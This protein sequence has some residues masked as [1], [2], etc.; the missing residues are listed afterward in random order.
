MAK[1]PGT[2]YK[3]MATV[4]GV[5]GVCPAGHQLGEHFP[6]GCFDG[7]GLCG[8][9]YHS[10]FGD[11]QTLQYG[12]NAPWWDGETVEEICPD[13]VNLVTVKLERFPRE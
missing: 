8:F 1:D 6:I 4:T 7:G 9:F 5:K 12:G 3:V 2:G 10:L 11:L 13:P